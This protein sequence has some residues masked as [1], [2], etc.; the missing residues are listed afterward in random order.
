MISQRYRRDYHGEFV[1][2]RTTFRDGVK[3]QDREWIPNA[4]E[5]HHVSGRAAIL[6]GDTDR[7]RFDYTKLQHHHGGLRGS[8]RL[9]TYGTSVTWQHLSLNFYV[10]TDS[11]TLAMI[12]RADYTQNTVVYTDRRRVL[13]FP[14]KFFLVPYCPLIADPA[15][16]M[17]LA[18]F[19]GHREIF[20]LGAAQHQ[21]RDPAWQQHVLE[22]MQCY[23]ACQFYFVGTEAAMPVSWRSQPN[24]RSMPVRSFVTH[25]DI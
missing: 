16:A 22:V 14:K 17:Y 12:D 9:Q 2:L 11:M 3:I 23:Y 1:I 13:E 18:A 6:I 10:N 15:L 21:D 7:S 19:D 5:N 8:Q 24:F 20:V 25:C 4:I